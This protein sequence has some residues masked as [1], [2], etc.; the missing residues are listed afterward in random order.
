MS[1]GRGGARPRLKPMNGERG[2]PCE[3]DESATDEN[4]EGVN[5]NQDRN[6]GVAKDPPALIQAR[7]WPSNPYS[8][9]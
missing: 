1:D 6:C 8:L 4:V 7:E 5:R 3:A 9:V 2:G